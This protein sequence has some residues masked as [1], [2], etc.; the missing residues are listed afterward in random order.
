MSVLR[1][2]SPDLIDTG[3]RPYACSYP[4]CC[5]RFSVQS[6][7]K[8]HA[9]VHRQGDEQKYNAC[10][11]PFKTQH[12]PTVL[13]P[14]RAALWLPPSASVCVDATAPS[15]HPLSRSTTN[16]A[17]PQLLMIENITSAPYG[18]RVPYAEGSETHTSLPFVP[19][20]N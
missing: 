17:Y 19:S 13:Y 9:R 14:S 2:A 3:E 12:L 7:L 15:P 18:S 8:R 1:T 10:Q 4:M 6:N 16:V 20:P 5:R 11:T